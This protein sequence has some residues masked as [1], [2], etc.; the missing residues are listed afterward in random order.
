MAAVSELMSLLKGNDLYFYSRG[1]GMPWCEDGAKREV[2]FHCGGRRV[3]VDSSDHQ[4]LEYLAS[5]LHHFVDPSRV[6]VAWEAKE[7]FSFLKGRTGVPMDMGS[8]FY[9][10]SLISSYLGVDAEMPAKFRDAVALLRS[11]FGMAGWEKFKEL[12]RGVYLP[13]VSRVIPDMETCCLVDNRRRMCVYPFY[14]PEGQ[15]N[16]RLKALVPSGFNYNPHSMGPEQRSSLRPSDYDGCFVQFDYRHM[17]VNVLQWLSGDPRL[18]SIL[19][20]GADPYRAIWSLVTRGEA[21]EAHRKLCKDVF[22]PVVFGQGAR[23]LASRVGAEEKIATRIIDTLVKTF[24]VAFD[25]V[26]SQSP[27]GDNMAEDFF[28][29]RRR[30]EGHE[31]YKSRNFSVQSPASMICLRKLVRLHEALSGVARICFHVHD[32]YYVVCAANEVEEVF[33]AGSEALEEEDPMFPGLRLKASC[34]FGN[35]L[36]DLKPIT[37]GQK[38]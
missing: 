2:V 32:G 34:N 15:A 7:V 29:R 17:E 8:S 5:S 18:G 20:S 4:S 6:V 31:F 38:P 12:Y 27:N 28:G 22:L 23:S 19:E 35:R 1:D 10:L 33:E 11:L 3:T 21:S 25:W 14:V 16:G 36:D 13:L 9:D 37:R 24:P 26:S 30:F